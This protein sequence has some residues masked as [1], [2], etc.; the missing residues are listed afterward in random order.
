[1]E[2]SLLIIVFTLLGSSIFG[3]TTW[4]E[5]STG[6]N[7][8]FNAI[9]FPTDQVGYIVGDD[10]LFMKSV[11]AGLSWQIWNSGGPS[12]FSANLVDVKFIDENMGFVVQEN[13]IWRTLDGG[14]SWEQFGAVTVDMC[15]YRAVFPFSEVDF[16]AGGSKCPE[17]AAIRHFENGS[18]TT[19]NLAMNFPDINQSVIELSFINS[20]NGLAATKSE[21]ILRTTDAGVTWDTISTGIQDSLT[22]VIMVNDTLCYAGYEDLNAQ[23]AGILKSE[24]GGVTWIQDV[25]SAT[26]F[27]PN[28]LTVTAANNGDIYSGGNSPAL[29]GGLIFE[30]VDGVN[31]EYQNV[32]Q[33]I[34]DMTSY[35][36]D[37]TF[38]VGDSGYL[39]VNTPVANL[40]IE[41]TN[42]LQLNVYPNP[43]VN[44]LKIE[45][46]NSETMELVILDASGRVLKKEVVGSGIKTINCTELSKGLYFLK[47]KVGNSYGVQ[48]FVKQ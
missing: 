17:G 22:S 45:N 39:V 27:Y 14:Q 11:D 19:G 29:S 36:S 24:D 26:F 47:A 43:V 10:G 4:Y 34:N 15:W 12:S 41:N 31:W 13:A 48:Q 42:L 30:S 5:I 35:G 7:K 37:V 21:Y 44:E 18:W 33:V 2:K 23:G 3:Q 40:G 28:Y 9:D 16:F 38:G 20:T 32:D 25:N 1:M 8:K 6:T 46:P